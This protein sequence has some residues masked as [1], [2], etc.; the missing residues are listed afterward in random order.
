ML[1][2]APPK[3]RDSLAGQASTVIVRIP[4]LMSAAIQLV[5]PIVVVGM[6]A[7]PSRQ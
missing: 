4:V 3:V 5:V 7:L 2:L 6:S 1:S